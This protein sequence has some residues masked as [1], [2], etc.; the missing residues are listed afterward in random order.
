MGFLSY[1]DYLQTRP[2][3]F[4]YA[5]KG[6]HPEDQF[7]QA[8]PD[9]NFQGDWVKQLLADPNLEKIR[10]VST[11]EGSAS[12]LFYKDG[13]TKTIPRK[14]MGGYLYYG[15]PDL[16][17]VDSAGP[18]L[19]KFTF[20]DG[21][22]VEAL[23]PRVEA[24]SGNFFESGNWIPYFIA[25]GGAAMLGGAAYGAY[26]AGGLGAETAGTGFSAF[27]PAESAAL[28]AQTAAGTTLAPGAAGGTG[29]MGAGTVGLDV[30]AGISASEAAAA[31]A[32]SATATASNIGGG[33]TAAEATEAAGLGAAGTYGSTATTGLTAMQK[34]QLAKM[35]LGAVSQLAGGG[36]GTPSGS[37]GG[38]LMSS[39]YGAGTTDSQL[40]PPPMPVPQY[41][42]Q[43]PNRFIQ[44]EEPWTK[45]WLNYGHLYP[46][47]A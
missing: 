19:D 28:A 16:V 1:S 10:P 6:T 3:Y 2:E 31:N 43:Q 8:L 42:Q 9:V 40:R 15:S 36:S 25:V 13:T 33:L 4:E 11:G 26:G 27:T 5:G 39:N 7:G 12:K 37:S 21:T 23:S 45:K 46:Y 30:G 44:N 41:T 34:L 18:E 22:T 17:K 32:A 29:L 38:G 14:E 24:K 35:G 47:G 20:A